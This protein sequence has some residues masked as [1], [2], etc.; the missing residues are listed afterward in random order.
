MFYFTRVL[1]A[2][3][4]TEDGNFYVAQEWS[5][6]KPFAWRNLPATRSD[7]KD[8]E[9]ISGEAKRAAEKHGGMYLGV[10]C[11]RKKQPNRLLRKLRSFFMGPEGH[12]G[13]PG[14][15]GPRGS[16]GPA[17][18]DVECPH[19]RMRRSQ[20]GTTLFMEVLGNDQFGYTCKKCKTTS[21]FITS[22]G[23]WVLLKPTEE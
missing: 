14:P 13:A 19:C 22:N 10:S 23:V 3:D 1:E 8:Y 21:T 9:A 6:R 11:R 5:I 15:Q 4:N 7:D 17:Y 12:M 20:T 2:P 16:M 18:D